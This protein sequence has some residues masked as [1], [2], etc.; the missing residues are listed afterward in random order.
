MVRC[1]FK[2]DLAMAA[3]LFEG[4]SDCRCIV[5]LVGATCFNGARLAALRWACTTLEGE[6][7]KWKNLLKFHLGKRI[8]V[9][10]VSV[11]TPRATYIG[12]KLGSHQGK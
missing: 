10:Q 12:S 4:C 5:G 6:Q 3:A 9:G 1:G 7:H 2:D 8:L 11:D